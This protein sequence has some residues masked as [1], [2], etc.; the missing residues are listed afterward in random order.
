MGL[1]QLK[2]DLREGQVTVDQLVDLIGMLQKQLADAHR[3]II[4]LEGRLGGGETPKL[5]EPFSLRAEEQRQAKRGG[6][7]GKQKRNLQR[8]G[9]LT[10]A[11]NLKLAECEEPVYPA[12][13]DQELCELS[14]R[15]P[16]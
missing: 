2:Q 11:D 5:N 13:V 14:H 3:R 7:S 6:K 16:V 4:E 9:R 8:R 12:W 15:R 10:T 1:D